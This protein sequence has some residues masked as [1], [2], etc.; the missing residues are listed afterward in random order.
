MEYHIISADGH[1]IEPPHMWAKFLDKKY[2]DRAPKLV[3]GIR[4][5]LQGGG[6][7]RGVSESIFVAGHRSRW[8][9]WQDEHEGTHRGGVAAEA[10]HA[11]ER[12]EFQ[13]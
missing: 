7:V 13:Q 10:E 1:N 12:G 2:L 4:V 5:A 8:I 11:L 9:E 3:D 6:S